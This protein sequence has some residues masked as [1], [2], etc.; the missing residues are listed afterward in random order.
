MPSMFSM[1]PEK[2]IETFVAKAQAVSATIARAT[3]LEEAAAYAANLAE[4]QE[5]CLLLLSGDEANLSENGKA[6]S[7]SRESKT[8]AAPGLEKSVSDALAAACADKKINIVQDNL[9]DYAAGFEVG[10]TVAEAGIAET[11][12]AFVPSTDENIRLTTMLCETSVVALPISKIVDSAE[13]LAADMKARM[14]GPDFSAFIT[15]ASRTADIERVLALGVH[16]PL[17]LHIVLVE[18]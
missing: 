18:A 16:G 15:G 5:G 7:R 17:E 11:G 12:T 13:D 2:R 14:A 4:S 6:L 9:R 10:F 8:I 3:S 1:S